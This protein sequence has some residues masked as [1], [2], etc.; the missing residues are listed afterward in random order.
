[1]IQLITLSDV[2]LAFTCASVI[3]N[4]W[5]ICLGANILCPFPCDTFV[6]SILLLKAVTV[7]ARPS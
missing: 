7:Y 2:L 5:I 6:G 1:M 3:A 4:I